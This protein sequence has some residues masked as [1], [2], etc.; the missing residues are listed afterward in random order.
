[1]QCCIR[2]SPLCVEVEKHI[3]QLLNY[4]NSHAMQQ[5][6]RWKLAFQISNVL[7]SNQRFESTEIFQGKLVL[8]QVNEI[9]GRR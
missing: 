9:K 8:H 7:T 3:D 1:M 6:I 5:I 4:N 2:T